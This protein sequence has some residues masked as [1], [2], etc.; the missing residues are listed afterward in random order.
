MLKGILDEGVETGEFRPLDSDSVTWMIYSMLDSMYYLLPEYFMY[1]SALN[2][3]VL[4][5]EIRDFIVQAI[6]RKEPDDPQGK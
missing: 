1:K 2:D 5:C 3:P 6:I 4:A